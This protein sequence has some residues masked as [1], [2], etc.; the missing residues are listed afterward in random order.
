MTSLADLNNS[1]NLLTEKIE[2]LIID[3]DALVNK[4]VTTE[5]LEIASAKIIDNIIKELSGK[6]NN[7]SCN[8]DILD[9]VKN[10]KVTNTTSTS[11]DKRSIFGLTKF[12]PPNLSKDS[13]LFN[14]ENKEK[15]EKMKKVIFKQ[16]STDKK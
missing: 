3:V 14:F 6:I 2:G 15:T 1:I 4:Y 9:T 10:I 12:S 5:E 7:W 8:K 11:E 16:F 13:K